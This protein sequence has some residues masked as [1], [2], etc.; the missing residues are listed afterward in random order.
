MY[1][2]RFENYP[3]ATAPVQRV[4]ILHTIDDDLDMGTFKFLSYGFGDFNETNE[5][6][7]MNLNVSK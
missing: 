7:T 4:Q 2:I 6:G 1:T 5:K 3:N